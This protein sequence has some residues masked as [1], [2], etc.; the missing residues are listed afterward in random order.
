MFTDFTIRAQG[1]PIKVHKVFLAESSQYFFSLFSDQENK[2]VMDLDKDINFE[3]AE[4]MI[5]FIYEDKVENMQVFAK[6]LMIAAK[7]VRLLG[8]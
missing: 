8:N 1:K 3:T 4:K 5:D 2:R 7:L 6:P